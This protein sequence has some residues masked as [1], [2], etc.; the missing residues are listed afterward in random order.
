VLDDAAATPSPRRDE[1][2]YV[3][4]VIICEANQGWKQATNSGAF[5]ASPEMIGTGSIALQWR[6]TVAAPVG[7]YRL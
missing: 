6:L 2:E 7:A 5:S 3:S 1:R 4:I